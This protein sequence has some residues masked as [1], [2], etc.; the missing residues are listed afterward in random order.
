MHLLTL[1]YVHDQ[2]LHKR[3]S[4]DEVD[5]IYLGS[6]PQ[7]L[8]K[9]SRAGQSQDACSTCAQY[10]DVQ[11]DLW[12]QCRKMCVLS[13]LQRHD[14]TKDSHSSVNLLDQTDSVFPHRVPEIGE[15][16]ASPESYILSP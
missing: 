8:G 14:I 4:Q 7:S 5:S 13:G 15:V 10:G 1:N 9:L 11:N 3:S 12:L 6:N 2:L 16:P